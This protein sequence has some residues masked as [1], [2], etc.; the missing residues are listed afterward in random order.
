[1]RSEND[2]GQDIA[3]RSPH[4]QGKR[5]NL[6]FLEAQ[7]K[8]AGQLLGD[9]CAQAT[10]RAS[11]ADAIPAAVALN[12]TAQRGGPSNFRGAQ[13]GRREGGLRHPV[14]AGRRTSR[15]RKSMDG[16]APRGQTDG[17][18]PGSGCIAGAPGC[19]QFNHNRGRNDAGQRI[20][21]QAVFHRKGR[22][23]VR[24]HLAGA[25]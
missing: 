1:M 14:S 18:F 10:G 7:A 17:Q 15:H 23:P 2:A 4:L 9:R 19:D 16:G 20:V 22:E 6:R 11:A 3:P 8:S 25:A 21:D 24:R 13:R 5:K 12:K